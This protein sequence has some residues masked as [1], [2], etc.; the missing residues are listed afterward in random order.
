MGLTPGKPEEQKLSSSGR[1]GAKPPSFESNS[2]PPP[3]FWLFF[4]ASII[5]ILW[6]GLELFLERRELFYATI[7][8]PLQAYYPHIADLFLQRGLVLAA[9]I[10]IANFSWIIAIGYYRFRFFPRSRSARSNAVD[11]EPVVSLDKLSYKPPPSFWRLLVTSIALILYAVAEW[12]CTPVG[13]F[14]AT[15]RDLGPKYSNYL[16]DLFLERAHYLILPIAT[17]TVAWIAAICHY[18]FRYFRK[19]R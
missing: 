11:K 12:I 7:G 13:F 2:T 18:R 1:A 16:S 5:A 17:T 14:Y 9:P 6:V 4:I 10:V 19:M 8:H 15:Q 3:P